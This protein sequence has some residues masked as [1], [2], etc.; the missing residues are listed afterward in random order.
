MKRY[1]FSL[2]MLVWCSGVMAQRQVVFTKQFAGSMGY[3]SSGIGLT[4]S[5]GKFTHELL[6]GFVPKYYGGPLDKITYRFTYIPFKVSKHKKVYWQPINPVVFASYNI[7]NKF[8]L[9]H[10]YKNYDQDYYWWSPALRFHVGANTAIF[11]QGKKHATMLYLEAN[12]N[13]RYITTYW[14]NTSNMKLSDIFYFGVGVKFMYAPE[15]FT[16]HKLFKVM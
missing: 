10:S 6:Y 3:L 7:G 2:M 8:S 13:D 16:K 1:I 9:M 12:T 4:D 11:W 14:D 5:S 15:R